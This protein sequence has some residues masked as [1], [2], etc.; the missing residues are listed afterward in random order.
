MFLEKSLFLRFAYRATSYPSPTHTQVNAKTDQTL[1]W[2]LAFLAIL[3]Q[4]DK[5]GC[6]VRRSTHFFF[7]GWSVGR[8]CIN[9]SCRKRASQRSNDDDDDDNNHDISGVRPVEERG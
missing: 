8:V 7:L 2:A 4:G 3:R 5:G 9:K 1:P 6:R